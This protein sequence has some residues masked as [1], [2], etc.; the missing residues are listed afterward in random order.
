MIAGLGILIIICRRRRLHTSKQHPI[1]SKAPKSGPRV[2][3]AWLSLCTV[4]SSRGLPQ[5]S[6]VRWPLWRPTFL[7]S[8]SPLLPSLPSFLPFIVSLPPLSSQLGPA[9]QGTRDQL[10]DQLRPGKLW[11][12]LQGSKTN[13]DQAGHTLVSEEA[14]PWVLA[15]WEASSLGS[16]VGWVDHPPLC[17]W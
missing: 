9:E 13:K 16:V 17:S 14:H 8:V 3:V 6:A 11:A 4:A 2:F 15:V 12:M 7:P 10:A 5:S 1:S